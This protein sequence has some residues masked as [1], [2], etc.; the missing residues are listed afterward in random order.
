MANQNR[1]TNA[2][3]VAVATATALSCVVL[4]A[5]IA[6]EARHTSNAIERLT[7]R[8]SAAA[9]PPAPPVAPPAARVRWE[10]RVETPSD[11]VLTAELAALGAEGWEIV[12]A[13]RSIDILGNPNYEFILKRPAR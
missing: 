6:W 8:T 13:R 7:L 5:F 10:Y 12:A 11:A 2:A 4:L 9:S 3:A 1:P